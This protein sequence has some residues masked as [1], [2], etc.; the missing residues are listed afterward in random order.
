VEQVAGL[1]GPTALA[2][3]PD[4][5]LF[6]AE[7]AGRVRVADASG[8]L[9]RDP[10]I[11]LSD[12]VNAEVDRGLLGLAVDA[13]FAT[14][15]LLYLLYTYEDNALN[16]SGPKTSR[17]TRIAV[18]NA[19]R[20]ENPDAPETTVLGSV[21]QAPCAPADSL[22]CIPSE[23][24]GHSVGTVRADPRWHVVARVGGRSELGRG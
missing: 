3:A 11:D 21:T 7:K 12:H 15:H 9:Q 17:L 14:N 8:R 10:M 4:G 16:P 18:T 5:R 22:D 20:P 6:I 2:Y 13:D 23:S 1:D 24:G 19:N